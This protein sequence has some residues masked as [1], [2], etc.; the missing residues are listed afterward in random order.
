MEGVFS[1][2]LF[3]SEKFE[4]ENLKFEPSEEF[5]CHFDPIVA[6]LL[7]LSIQIL[8]NMNHILLINLINFASHP[9]SDSRYLTTYRSQNKEAIFL[10]ILGSQVMTWLQFKI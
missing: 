7:S 8:I 10:V 9:K 2:F 3:C 5:L 6:M 1:V 4:A